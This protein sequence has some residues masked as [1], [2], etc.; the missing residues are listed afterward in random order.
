MMQGFDRTDTAAEL[1]RPHDQPDSAA[2]RIADHISTA[3]DAIE[4]AND[5]DGLN[6]FI[7]I[8]RNG[9]MASAQ[10]ADERRAAGR[11]LGPLDGV[12]IAVKDNLD[13]A[14]L[15]TTFGLGIYRDRIPDRDADVVRRLR[16]AGAVIVGK[17]NMT[18]LA[19]GTVGDNLHY[20]DVEN[21]LGHDRYPG[22]SSSGSA[23]AVAAGLVD[24]A[25]GSDTGGSI[26][27]P[28]AACGIVGLKPTFG[29]T[30]ND[31]VSVCTRSMD[32]V[33]P[34]SISSTLA[35][36][37][38]AA[39]QIDGADD[40]RARIGAPIIGT[41][42][43]VLTGE[44]LDS[45][46][47]EVLAAFEP[48]PRHLEALGC[49]IHE[50]DLRLDLRAIDEEIATPLGADLFDEYGEEIRRAGH[51]AFGPELWTWYER[52]ARIDADTYAA[53]A[54]RKAALTRQVCDALAP[55][56]I[57]I[58]PTNRTRTRTVAEGLAADPFER[59]GN[60]VLWDVTG[61]PSATVPFGT[62][63]DG[64]PLGLLVNGPLGNDA[65]V[66]QVCDAIERATR[67]N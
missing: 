44:F 51:D 61:H 63:G 10:A 36:D 2:M 18:E 5:E 7:T 12:P 35:A 31:G 57:V 45:C 13:T 67:Q 33:G 64:F 19:C 48:A 4:I 3:L 15:R 46:D 55:F 14:S 24:H 65:H 21:P 41:R 9:A 11:L 59:V 26:R 22:G 28:A 1:R 62:D 39:I 49:E 6:A 50:L 20:G 43:A 29:R 40:P 32:H 53:A 17:T 54:E 25:I 8:D 52:Y 37:T 47:A 23:A 27:H 16:A 60:L 66:L 42:V 58:C 38:L 34:M 30:A 56:D